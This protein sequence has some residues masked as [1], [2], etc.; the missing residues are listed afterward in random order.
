M[1]S[2]FHRLSSEAMEAARICANKYLCKFIGKENFHM[3][4]RIHPFHILR[5]NKMLSCAGADRLQTG[6]RGAYGKP[7][8]SA[9]RVKI[10]QILMSCRSKPQFEGH[11][12]E[13]FRR[14]K[15]KY[16]GRQLIIKSRNWG[17]TKLTRPEFEAKMGTNT[18]LNCGTHVRVCYSIGAFVLLCSFVLP[19]SLSQSCSESDWHCCNV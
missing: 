1:N 15:F 7:H 5:I 2:N 6:M 11:L 12:V 16:P 14:C 8:G 18:L 13:A 10:G 17:F 19:N 9:A 4:M 3:R